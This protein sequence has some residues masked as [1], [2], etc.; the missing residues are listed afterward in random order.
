[1]LNFDKPLYLSWLKTKDIV[2]DHEHKICC[3]ELV[4]DINDDAVLDDWAK[5]IGSHNTY[6]NSTKKAVTFSS[7]GV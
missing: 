1:M 4:Y 5:H 3:F 6:H 7:I 2:I